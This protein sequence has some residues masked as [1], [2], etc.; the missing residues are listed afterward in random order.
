MTTTLT[1]RKVGIIH[2]RVVVLIT[3]EKGVIRE[4]DPNS[5]KSWKKEKV[6]VA[7]FPVFSAVQRP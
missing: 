1:T 2:V 7:L 3:P 4:H 6:K 5:G